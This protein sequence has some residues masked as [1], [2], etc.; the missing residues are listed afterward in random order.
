METFIFQKE[1]IERHNQIKG[2]F[3]CSGFD[4]VS[5][6]TVY[7]L[8]SY[9]QMRDMDILHYF[10]EKSDDVLIVIAKPFKKILVDW[11]NDGS[12]LNEHLIYKDVRIASKTKQNKFKLLYPEMFI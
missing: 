11:F 6:E 7:F 4:H 10:N 8:I 9:K 12:H 2:S 5:K 3:I 1:D